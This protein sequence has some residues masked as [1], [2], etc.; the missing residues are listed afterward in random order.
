[1]SPLSRQAT[2]KQMH[3]LMSDRILIAETGDRLLGSSRSLSI[4][5]HLI[6]SVAEL[7]VITPMQKCGSVATDSGSMQRI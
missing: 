3:S 6:R 7:R 5:I 1:V 2:L 4:D